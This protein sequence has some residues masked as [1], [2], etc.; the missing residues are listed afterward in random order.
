M[1]AA[2]SGGIGVGAN[3]TALALNLREPSPCLWNLTGGS[4]DHFPLN[5]AFLGVPGWEGGPMQQLKQK[6]AVCRAAVSLGLPG[7]AKG[8]PVQARK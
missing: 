6:G 7:C 5:G 8:A 2:Y 4:E 1:T 3:S